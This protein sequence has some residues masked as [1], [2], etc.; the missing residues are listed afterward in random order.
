MPPG[1]RKKIKIMI[2]NKLTRYLVLMMV[3]L[4]AII[5][6]APEIR[7]QERKDA[8]GIR[9]VLFIGDSMTGW[10]ADRLNAYG[11]K[12]GFKV[13]SVVWDGA[14][15]EKW[16]DSDK[17][18][19]LIA[20]YKPDAVFVS[21]GMNELFEQNPERRLSAAV[22]KITR[23][24]GDVPYLWIGPPSWPEHEKGEKLTDWLGER[25][26]EGRYFN[27]F[28]L[29]LPRQG[30][31]NP[32]PSKAGIEKWMDAVAEWIPEHTDLRFR[33]L[34]NPGP[35]KMSRPETFI[36]RKINESL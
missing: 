29:T 24:F 14:T 32:H 17:I 12:N 33:T 16:A 35:G 7:A 1:L 4:A 31:T 11:E 5:W 13:S 26:G 34:D 18:E 28:H 10:M 6:G 22:D 20:E 27:S 25:L 9:N 36:Y 2:S 3:S 19:S 21:L 30:K 23:S 15:I 8:E